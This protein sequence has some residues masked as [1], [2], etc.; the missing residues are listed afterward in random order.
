MGKGLLNHNYVDR[1]NTCTVVVSVSGRVLP[2]QQTEAGRLAH[3]VSGFVDAI[4]IVSPR[5]SKIIP[6]TLLSVREQ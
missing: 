3:S 5:R 1:N 4:R 2:M 6:D